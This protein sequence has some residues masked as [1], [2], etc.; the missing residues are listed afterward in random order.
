MINILLTSAGRRNY[1]VQY[2]KE[3]LHPYGGKIHV[4][5]SN[6]DSSA[7]YEADFYAVSPLI[8]DDRFE[9]F[10]LDYCI[11]NKINLIISLFDIEL[12]VFA[13]LKNK[14][15]DLGIHILVADK[16]ITD[17]A[18]DKWLTQEFLKTNN[19]NVVST[20]LDYDSFNKDFKKGMVEFPVFVKPRWGMGSISVHKATDIDEVI[21]YLKKTIEAIDNSYLKYE[22]G[23][24]YEN[25]VLIQSSLPGQEYGLDVINNLKGEY[26]TTI[27]KKK[28]AMRSG[29]TDAAITV[30]EPILEELGKRIS[31]LTMHPG[32]LDM[33]V[34]FDGNSPYVLEMNPRF[35]GGYPFSH[36]SGVNLPKAIVKWYL[37]EKVSVEELLTPKI[38]V[39]SMKGIM[40]YAVK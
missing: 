36:I 28:I 7:L 18:N 17:T 37:N 35:G 22:S 21:F 32:N 9:G 8:Y 29:E 39:K 12:P 30:R 15:S 40:M 6:S 5:N 11:E 1:M 16:E 38:G 4:M 20:Y 23:Q 26:Q 25:R 33:D 19:F 3:V 31:E 14:F 2:F 13:R 10:L 27:V 34:F 24:S